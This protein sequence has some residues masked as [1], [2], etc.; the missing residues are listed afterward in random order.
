M[1]FIFQVDRI[2]FCLFL[3]K[4]YEIYQ[5]VLQQYFPVGPDVLDT[6]AGK[7]NAQ[8]YILAF[9]SMSTKV[10]LLLGLLFRGGGGG[11]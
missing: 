7:L 5:E 4:D 3:P 6:Q 1:L 9:N 8:P 2:V 11:G 10:D